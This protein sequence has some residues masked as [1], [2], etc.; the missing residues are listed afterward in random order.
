WGGGRGGAGPSPAGRARPWSSFPRAS[1]QRFQKLAP[2]AS[3]ADFPIVLGY[4]DAVEA[5]LRALE[6]A[7][8]AGAGLLR[9]LDATAL[10]AP[11]GPIRLDHNRQA[12]VTMHLSRVDVGARGPTIRTFRDVANVDQAFG[13]YFSATTPTP[14]AP[15]PGCHGA[16]PPQWTKEVSRLRVPATK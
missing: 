11:D 3:P 9:A 7:H 4:Y 8:T 15:R 13:G 12:I 16:P 10:D 5:T 14:P 2:P 1:L 6:H